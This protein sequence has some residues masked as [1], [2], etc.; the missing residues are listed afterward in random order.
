M[1]SETLKALRGAAKGLIYTSE[2]DAPLKAIVWTSE[3]VE[4]ASEPL[5]AV[6]KAAGVEPETIEVAPVER[7]FGQFT[8][9]QDWWG[10]EE[11]EICAQFGELVKALSTLPGVAAHR[12]GDGPDTRGRVVLD[13][14]HPG[15]IAAT[16]GDGWCRPSID[17]GV[18]AR[19]ADRHWPER[20][21]TDRM[22][23]VG[24]SAPE[25]SRHRRTGPMIAL[26]ALLATL[27]TYLVFSEIALGKRGF[28]RTAASVAARNVPRIGWPRRALVTSAWPSLCWW[29]RS[30]SWPSVS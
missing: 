13:R 5:S 26:V 21:R 14:Q 1:V 20:I 28:R 23:D 19:L 15:A 17:P 6:A 7:F 11:K 10:N 29:R 3:D 27:G 25:Q 24:G 22:V 4:G 12:V 2:S 16:S 18:S 9:P 8:E 30:F